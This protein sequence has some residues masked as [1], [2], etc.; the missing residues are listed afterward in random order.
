MGLVILYSVDRTDLKL[1]MK[2][3]CTQPMKRDKVETPG[4]SFLSHE[5]LALTLVDLVSTGQ[6]NLASA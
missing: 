4:V 1:S 6:E 2:G 3:P 5:E